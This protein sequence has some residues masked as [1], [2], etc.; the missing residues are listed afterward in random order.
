MF[1]TS[2]WFTVAWVGVC[3]RVC[4]CVRERGRDRERQ[5]KSTNKESVQERKC[6]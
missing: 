5:K 3:A 4:V 1:A 2:V 6:V